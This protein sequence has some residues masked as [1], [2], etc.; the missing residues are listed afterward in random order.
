MLPQS[1]E[2][3]DPQFDF[4]AALERF[5]Q[6]VKAHGPGGS[7]ICIDG[8]SKPFDLAGYDV[9]EQVRKYVQHLLGLLRT[10]QKEGQEDNGKLL[11]IAVYICMITGKSS[12]LYQFS[13]D[14][15]GLIFQTFR[16]CSALL[17]QDFSILP[18][19]GEE[20]RTK[21]CDV[22]KRLVID[23]VAWPTT[24]VGWWIYAIPFIHHWDLSERA[25]SDWLKLGAWKSRL[26][27]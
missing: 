14:D 11:R 2:L 19:I 1:V 13:L 20:T 3:N 8:K 15:C 7:K 4:L 22:L 21:I 5:E 12:T 23:V 6:V 17:F 26:S 16:D 24:P 9:K 18:E 27:G 10:R 25:D